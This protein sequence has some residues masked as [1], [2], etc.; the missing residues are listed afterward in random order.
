[1]LGITRKDDQ[2]SVWISFRSAKELS[3]YSTLLQKARSKNNLN[4]ALSRVKRE[5]AYLVR[6]RRT[7]WTPL[8]CRRH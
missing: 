6:G 5:E 8:R 3:E 1:M 7:R 4:V 2:L